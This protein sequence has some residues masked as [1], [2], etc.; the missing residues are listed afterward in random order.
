VSKAQEKFDREVAQ[1]D[2]VDKIE[3]KREKLIQKVCD[4]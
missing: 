3:E 2:T 1:E 4:A